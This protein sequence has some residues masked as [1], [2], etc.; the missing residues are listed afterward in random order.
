MLRDYKSMLLLVALRSEGIYSQRIK[1]TDC[2]KVF[3]ALFV[4]K[5]GHVTDEESRISGREEE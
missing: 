1:T 3:Y 5:H 2:F 4:T